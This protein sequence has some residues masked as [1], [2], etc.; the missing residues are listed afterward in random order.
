MHLLFANCMLDRQ[1]E[2]E[3]VIS[4][5]LLTKPHHAEELEVLPIVGPG[6]VGKSTLVA[7]LV[8]KIKKIRVSLQVAHQIQELKA[9][10]AEESKRHKRYKLDGLVG[11]SGASPNNKVDLRMCALW[12]ETEKLVGLD[13]PRDEII[14]WLMPAEGEVKPSQQVRTLSIVGCAGLGK[15][16]LAKQVYEKI[17][18]DFDCKA[19]VSVSLNPQIKDVLVKICSQVG[20]TTSMVD[21]EPIL[22]D[23]LREHLQHKRWV[24]EGFVHPEPGKTLYEVGLKYFNVLINRSLIQPWKEEDG[25]VLSCRVHDVILNFL[26]SKS[27]EENFLT[28]LDSSGVPP[29]PLH[30]NKVRRLSLQNS[31]QAENV[32]S[33]IKSIKPHVRSLA[34]FVD[35]KE[36]HPLSKFEVVRVLDLENCGS[37]RNIHLENIEMLLQLR[38]LS[39]RRTSVSEL[40]IGIGQ[41]QRLETL[42]IRET[43]VE[44]FPSTIVLLEK[45]ARLF[46]GSKVK[47]P[48]EGF[49]KM[50][51]L[52][53]LTC[54]MVRKQPLGFLK[55]LG[56]LTNLEILEAIWEDYNMGEEDYYYEGSEWGIFTSSLQALGSHK[57]HSLYFRDGQSEIEICIPMDSSFPAL[58]KLRT[59]S[60]GSF[61]SLPI[62]MGSL[63]NLE[64]LNLGISEFTEDDM[65][66]LGGMPALEVLVISIGIYTAPFTI[67]ASGAFQRLKSFKVDSLYGVL[68]MPGSMPN[69]RH[70]HAQLYYTTGVSHD[71]GLQHLASLVKSSAAS[72]DHFPFVFLGRESGEPA[73]VLEQSRAG[74]GVQRYEGGH[75]A[76][77]GGLAGDHRELPAAPLRTKHP[78]ARV[79]CR[80]TAF[81]GHRCAR[82]SPTRRRRSTTAGMK[83]PTPSVLSLPPRA[84]GWVHVASLVNTRL[85]TAPQ[86]IHPH[87]QGLNYLQE[88]HDS[89]SSM[90]IG[91]NELVMF[92]KNYPRMYR[93]PYSMHLLLGNCMFGRQRETELVIDFLLG[94]KPHSGEELEVLPIVGPGRVGKSTLVAHVSKDERVRDHFSQIIFLSDHD[95]KSDKIM[96]L[97]TTG[98]VTLKYPPKEAYWYFFKT[99]TFQGMDPE[100]HPR[101]ASL[102]M[103]IAMTLNGSL[104]V[105]NKDARLLRDNFDQNFWLKVLAFKRRITQK[106]FSKFGM[107][108]SDLLDHSRLTHLGRIHGASET[109]IVYDQYQCSSE[110]VVPDIKM[111]DVAY[112]SVKPHGKFEA[113]AWSFSRPSALDVEDHLRWVLLRAQ[114]IDEEALGR[115][116]TNRAMLQQLNMLRD[117][118]YRGYFKLDIFRYQH[119]NK[120]W[121]KYKDFE[122]T[123]RGVVTLKYL[124]KETYW[125]FFK[126]LAFGTNDPEKHPRLAYLAMEMARMLN[127]NFI[128][129]NGT[130]F[131]LRDNFDIDFWCKVLA[132]MNRIRD[133]AS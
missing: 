50:K 79:G 109:L 32:V 117:A 90:I 7:H 49:G 113:L 54:F 38:Y 13:E 21:D 41:V 112:G 127:G 62:W 131:V 20:V 95:L 23:K 119:H 5:L 36:L 103:K 30:S 130:A 84:V 110:E 133:W 37:L 52:E 11:S 65:Q 24:A 99:L 129:A 47:F 89:L 121:N 123:A 55:E 91:S 71:L 81:L 57:L 22:V 126:T 34:C 19:L 61:N 74:G 96:K 46:V 115:N 102:A 12:V 72:D 75:G 78:A 98:G 87:P 108:P 76:R 66:V 68:F 8:R 43:E 14:R 69:L 116:I 64:L 10:V 97:G 33:W 94:T 77:R 73:L 128:G 101:L 59:F 42:D 2:K 39:I 82:R 114:V 107:H 45:L 48:A 26:A 58:S 122:R 3:P 56:Q 118:M 106:S 15:T 25:L 83:P 111:A 63:A 51:G 88:V 124:R 27:F 120:E 17:K 40:P 60:I 4:F 100:D 31:Y 1:M 35:C 70:L 28:L 104:I 29:S 67:S 18:G 85:R 80:S 92:L 44:Q 125:Y 9:R 86:G 16:T 53:Q 93:Q 105:G 6:R 132:F